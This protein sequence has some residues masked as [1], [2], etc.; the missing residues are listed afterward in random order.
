M[1]HVKNLFKRMT[2]DQEHKNN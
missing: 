2:F 1:D